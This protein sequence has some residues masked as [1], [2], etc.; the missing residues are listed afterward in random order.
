MAFGIGFEAVELVQGGVHVGLH[1]GLGE[2]ELLDVGLNQLQL[3]ERLFHLFFIKV[4]QHRVAGPEVF[5]Q[6]HKLVGFDVVQGL[7]VGL[8]LFL[9]TL[10]FVD[11]GLGLAVAGGF[12]C[13]VATN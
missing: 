8:H 9:Q 10:D 6:G 4:L 2:L 13:V 5:L 3:L 11:G 7:R 1:Q 12:R